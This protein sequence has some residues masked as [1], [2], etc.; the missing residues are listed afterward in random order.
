[1]MDRLIFIFSLILLSII[2]GLS[3]WFLNQQPNSPFQPRAKMTINQVA[4]TVIPLNKVSVTEINTEKYLAS[5]SSN[6]QAAQIYQLNED[7]PTQAAEL[8]NTHEY[9]EQFALTMS[10][11]NNWSISQP[12][13]ALFW[14][15]TQSNKFS[16]SQYQLILRALLQNYAKA[17]PDFVYFQLKYMVSEAYWHELIFDIAQAW[18]NKDPEQAIVW[19]DDLQNDQL[20]I[21]YLVGAH[22]VVLETYSK[23]HADYARKWLDD[24]KNTQL[25]R[26]LNQQVKF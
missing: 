18:V 15:Q 9:P 7:N 13:D 20:P 14:L 26:L 17:E 10:L 25:K 8:L 1:M 6:I 24:M 19:L 23:S 21:E 11:I 16:P 5:T 22:V 12:Q 2:G 3:Y 4:P